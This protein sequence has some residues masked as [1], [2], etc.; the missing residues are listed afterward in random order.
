MKLNYKNIFLTIGTSV[1]FSMALHGNSPILKIC[2]N[3]NPVIYSAI[4]VT[5]PVRKVRSHMARVANSIVSIESIRNGNSTHTSGF[6]ISENGFIVTNYFHIK[7]ADQ[8]RVT[9][10]DGKELPATLVQ[11]GNTDL[12]AAIIKIEGNDFPFLSLDTQKTSVP[13]WVFSLGSASSGNHL[14]TI[15]TLKEKNSSKNISTYHIEADHLHSGSPLFDIEGNVIG[16]HLGSY[17]MK[18]KRLCSEPLDKGFAIPLS[19]LQ[20]KKNQLQEFATEESYLNSANFLLYSRHFK[21]LEEIG[22]MDY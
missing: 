21:S 6:L 3:L 10:L 5:E 14:I 4:N 7:D 16:M 17:P 20:Q 2:P 22:E 18:K 13:I 1:L 9:L 12:D 15:N 19:V 11:K 8:I